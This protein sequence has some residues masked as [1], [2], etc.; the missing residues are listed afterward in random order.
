MEYVSNNGSVRSRLDSSMDS[1]ASSPSLR[2]VESL[3]KNKHLNPWDSI[4]KDPNNE[5]NCGFRLVDNI[6]KASRAQL[7]AGKLVFLVL[8]S[9]FPSSFVH[10]C[11][12]AGETFS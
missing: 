1:N 9:I 3:T 4:L 11:A 7:L 2:K 8:V 5:K 6:R 12:W 10:P